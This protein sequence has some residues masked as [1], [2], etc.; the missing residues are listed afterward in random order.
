MQLLL[1]FCWIF[2]EGIAFIITGDYID[3]FTWIAFL[4][5]FHPSY[6]Q[7]RAAISAS[8]IIVSKPMHLHLDHDYHQSR[9]HHSGDFDRYRCHWRNPKVI[10][11]FSYTP[12]TSQG[13]S[14]PNVG[15]PSYLTLRSRHHTN[16]N[17]LTQKVDFSFP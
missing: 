9:V 16:N 10:C 13:Q 14:N 15:L 6:P 12:Y 8:F 7:T 2:G 5:R 1:I 17:M 3:H 11:P 4:Q